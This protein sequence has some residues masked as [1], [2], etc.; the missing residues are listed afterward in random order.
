MEERETVETVLMILAPLFTGLN[1]G[2]NETETVKL[3]SQSSGDALRFSLC[4]LSYPRL[5]A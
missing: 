3:L 5:S 4:L 1:P 2:V